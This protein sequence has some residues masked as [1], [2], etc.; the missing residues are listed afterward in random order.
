MA[1]TILTLRF[2]TARAHAAASRCFKCGCGRC[3]VLC[4]AH[5]CG[6]VSANP[7]ERVA[8]R[9]GLPAGPNASVAIEGEHGFRL[10]SGNLGAGISDSAPQVADGRSTFPVS[11][12]RE[13]LSSI[14]G[15]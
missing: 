4:S 2:F 8:E 12:V 15:L 11:S 10:K 9:R 6:S 1:V 3:C 14:N 7:N 13:V 5:C